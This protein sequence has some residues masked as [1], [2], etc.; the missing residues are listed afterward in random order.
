METRAPLSADVSLPDIE[1]AL[2]ERRIS[3]SRLCDR[4]DVAFS[5]WHRWRTQA[6]VPQRSTWRRVVDAHA[7]LLAEHDAAAAAGKAA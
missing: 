4:A 1:A 6:R 2:A 5:T 3:I 7:A